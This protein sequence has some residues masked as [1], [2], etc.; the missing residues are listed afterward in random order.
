MLFIL[1][2]FCTPDKNNKF[3]PKGT[4]MKKRLISLSLILILLISSVAVLVSCADDSTDQG[5]TTTP[6][7]FTENIKEESTTRL[8]LNCHR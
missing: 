2:W 1:K 8:Y 7:D 6:T 3:L 5:D 4:I